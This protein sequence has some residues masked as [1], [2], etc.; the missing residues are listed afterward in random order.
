MDEDDDKPQRP[1]IL[2]FTPR[3]APVAETESVLICPECECSFW[4]IYEELGT[5]CAWC[6]WV[7]EG[8][9]E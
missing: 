3:E 9:D 7:M 4:I 5:Q 6:N 8:E 1:N 2:T